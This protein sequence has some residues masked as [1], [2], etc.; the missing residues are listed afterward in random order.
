MITMLVTGA[1]LKIEGGRY[2]LCEEKLQGNGCG[3][4]RRRMGI[5][6]HKSIDGEHH[7]G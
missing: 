5:H 2:T 7:N 4:C 3:R 6:D 1:K